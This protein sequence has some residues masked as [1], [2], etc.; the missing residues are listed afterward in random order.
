[1]SPALCKRE[2]PLFYIAR[3]GNLFPLYIIRLV[4]A[5][6]LCL[7]GDQ[8]I[9]TGLSFCLLVSLLAVR[10][11]R[12]RYYFCRPISF[13][14]C[15]FFF[16]GTFLASLLSP[17]PFP[18]RLLSVIRILARRHPWRG[19]A[20]PFTLFCSGY[21][22]ERGFVFYFAPYL[23][24][25]AATSLTAVGSGSR[26]VLRHLDTAFEKLNLRSNADVVVL[27]EFGCMPYVS[28]FSCPEDSTS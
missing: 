24:S 7:R 6:P 28:S 14:F 23:Y 27:V 18:C 1:M 12:G 17:R 15:L 20:P 2:L 13:P 21:L 16:F 19:V 25:G 26:V 4:Q 5:R 22:S 10:T 11:N 9:L 3:L 8:R